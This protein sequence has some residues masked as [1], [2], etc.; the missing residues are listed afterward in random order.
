MS[1]LIDN[2]KHRQ[3]KLKGII[4]DL[5]AGADSEDI[6]ARFSDLLD[7]VGATE[8][9]DIEQSLINEGLPVEEVQRLCDVHVAV[10]K[11]SLDKQKDAVEAKAAQMDN[12]VSTALSPLHEENKVITQLVSDIKEILTKIS[13]ADGGSNIE[14]LLN[15]WEEKHKQ[16]LTVDQHYSKKENI[17]FPYLERYGI[18]GPPSVMWGTHDEIRAALK[19]VSKVLEHV[20]PKIA[21]PQLSVEIGNIVLPVLNSVSEM[22]YKEENIL[23]PMCRETFTKDEWK[24]I[25]AQFKDPMATVYKKKDGMATA[26]LSGLGLPGIDLDV[27]VLTPEQINLVLTHLPIDITF[28]NEKDEV[29]Y[30]SLGP[31]R[32]F[33]RT[34][35][36]IGRKVQFCHPPASM[37]V[38]EQ[39]LADFK[40]GRKDHADFWINAKGTMLYIRYFA[41]RDKNGTYRG[42]LEVTQDITQIQKLTGEKR[43]YDYEE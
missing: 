27:G 23:F 34:R 31:E 18:S 4:R 11:E 13:E 36:V 14:S 42:T 30:F 1:E 25:A 19:D 38:V 43:I 41:V 26:A 37:G 6:K 10:F 28:V 2:R 32:F 40:S 7:Q 39:I 20:D 12:E 21:S 29:A 24:E 22:I 5:H 15:E 17:L 16:L 9:A 33:E 35:A 3:E 8:I